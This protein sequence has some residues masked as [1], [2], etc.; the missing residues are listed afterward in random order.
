MFDNAEEQL[1]STEILPERSY[2][3]EGAK[4]VRELLEK[5][6]ISRRAYYDLVGATVG[7]QFLETNVFAYH[8]NSREIAFQSTVMKRYCEE[9][10][11]LWEGK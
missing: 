8:L 7:D 9:N 5:G 6:S 2:H 4:I 10:S 11:A 3:K 1:L